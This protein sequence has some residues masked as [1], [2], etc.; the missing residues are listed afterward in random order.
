MECK[1]E[2]VVLTI[3]GLPVRIKPKWNVNLNLDVKILTFDSV[4]IKPKWNVNKIH[5]VTYRR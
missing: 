4:R 3:T 5:T 1:Y 2:E